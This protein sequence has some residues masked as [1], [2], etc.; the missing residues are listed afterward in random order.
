MR[1]HY[2]M[3][4]TPDRPN[5]TMQVEK[6]K[7]DVSCLHWLVDMLDAQGNSCLKTIIYCRTYQDCSL[8]YRHFLSVFGPNGT[9]LESRPFD[10][11]HSKTSQEIKKHIENAV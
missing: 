3:V 4:C 5:I 6:V 2:T 7:G 10:M 1:D 11:V 8:V 9:E